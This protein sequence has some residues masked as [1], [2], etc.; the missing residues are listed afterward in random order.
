MTRTPN[1]PAGRRPAGF[2]LIELLVVIA[3][4]AVLIGMVLPAVMRVRESANR[5]ECMNN[6]KQ[7]ALACHTYHDA[8]NML[9]PN[10]GNSAAIAARPSDANVTRSFLYYVAPHLEVGDPDNPQAVKTFVCPS[11]RA[12][13]DRFTDYAGAL[14]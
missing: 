9:P 11:R 7:L 5:T 3:I 14:Q 13:T 2:T 12:A 1:S 10:G 8:Y 4:I 6:Q